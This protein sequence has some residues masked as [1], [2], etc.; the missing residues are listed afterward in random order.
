MTLKALRMIIRL[1]KDK[2][3][4]GRIGNKNSQLLPPGPKLLIVASLKPAKDNAH[5]KILA[6]KNKTPMLPPNSGP[7]ARLIM[8]KMNKKY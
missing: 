1:V 3:R 2:T 5:E 8:S 6:K 7:R 4:F